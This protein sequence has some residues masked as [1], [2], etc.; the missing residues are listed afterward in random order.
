ML[1]PIDDQPVESS[2]AARE[3]HSGC[4]AHEREAQHPAPRWRA[5]S[6]LGRRLDAIEVAVS[7]WLVAHS[8]KLLRVSLGCVFLGFGV[9][10]FFPMVSPAEQLVMDTTSKLTFDLVPGSVSIIAIAVLECVIGL[11]LLSGRALRGVMYLLAI[12]LVGILAPVVLLGDRLFSGPHNAPTL[13]GQYVLKDVILVAAVLVVAATVR[14]ARL[15]ESRR[16][17][18]RRPGDDQARTPAGE[19]EGS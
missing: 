7:G 3:V 1:D 6:R 18:P 12:E 8:I 14:G 2:G 13:Q 10:K 11:W 4:D 5:R 15:T 16:R 9:L 19:R 17:R